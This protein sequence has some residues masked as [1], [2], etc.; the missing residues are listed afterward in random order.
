VVV[1]T[2][3]I[4]EVHH[5]RD[6][7]MSY[8]SK[9]GLD[10]ALVG[11]RMIGHESR[12][13]HWQKLSASLALMEL[14]YDF[15]FWIDGDALIA[16]CTKSP[17][18]FLDQMDLAGTSWLFSGDTLI[19]NSGVVL[20]KNTQVARDILLE[21]DLLWY[22]EWSNDMKLRDNAAM[23]AYLAG[24]RKPSK[25]D[26]QKAYT[27]ADECY[28]KKTL[29][30]CSDIVQGNNRAL[31]HIGVDPK[32]LQHISYVPK[33]AINAYLSDL[34]YLGSNPQATPLSDSIFIFHCAG[35]TD[36]AACIQTFLDISHT[37]TLVCQ[38]T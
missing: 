14:D 33:L 13:P 26:L 2:I 38:R 12:E 34:E 10:Y 3:S 23:A 31:Q 9:W 21:I 18:R 32:L 28:E 35:Q 15:V 27:R 11:R 16:D 6:N 5:T 22:P 24:A 17:D 29:Q 20:F 37:S 7:H 1:L 4:G 25:Q 36:K 19:I 8:C 30:F